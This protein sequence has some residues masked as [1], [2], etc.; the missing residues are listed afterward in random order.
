MPYGFHVTHHA[1]DLVEI[2]CERTFK[3]PL[4]LPVLAI[5]SGR[6]ASMIAET[7]LSRDL[8]RPVLSCKGIL[9]N[10]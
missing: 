1:N 7:I 8:T 3:H 4:E 5:L 6:V 2:R 10:I 9:L